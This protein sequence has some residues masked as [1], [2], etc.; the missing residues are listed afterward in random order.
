[1]CPDNA[2]YVA[3]KAASLAL[4]RKYVRCFR[5]AA[6]NFV[7]VL[8]FMLNSCLHCAE[9]DDHKVF[10]QDAALLRLLRRAVTV[11]AERVVDTKRRALLFDPDGVRVDCDWLSACHN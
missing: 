11:C 8:S 6:I 1:M 4:Y 7:I 3:A 10:L 9:P 2:C 5:Y